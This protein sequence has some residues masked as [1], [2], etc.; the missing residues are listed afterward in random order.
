VNYEWD[1][2]YRENIKDV[3]YENAVLTWN[4]MFI[5]VIV[6]VVL[7]LYYATTGHDSMQAIRYACTLP[8]IFVISVFAQMLY[9]KHHNKYAL[10]TRMSYLFG[11][12][13][14][15]F[16]MYMIIVSDVR[17]SFYAFFLVMT[18]QTTLIV[19]VPR[20]KLLMQV[21]WFVMMLIA[22][23]VGVEDPVRSRSV[24]IHGVIVTISSYL[25]GCFTTWRKLQGF[26]NARELLYIST[27]D[28]L[29]RLKNRDCLYR[30]FDEWS[31]AG[32]IRGVMI[33][34]INSFKH[35]NDTY[36][37]IFGDQAI[38]YVAGILHVCE[39]RYGISFYRYGGD[40]FVGLVLTDGE[41][42]P[43]RLITHIKHRVSEYQLCTVDGVEITIQVSGGYED[44]QT[45][46]SLEQCVNVADEVMYADKEQMK[47]EG[48]VSA[49]ERV[50]EF[51]PGTHEK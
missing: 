40:E 8:V 6:D 33:F 5:M 38:Q 2:G 41:K 36:G 27:H 14:L 31:A 21:I 16:C 12:F 48:L 51:I 47:R 29:T 45:G 42:E 9:R 34:D 44:Y 3:A 18:L 4:G 1:R 30:D 11:T 26:D 20:R 17:S 7:M 15:L 10:T 35:L 43:G 39:E 24:L 22:N 32:R 46:M 13:L 25:F 19:D 23:S 28:R 50:V 49:E 37:H